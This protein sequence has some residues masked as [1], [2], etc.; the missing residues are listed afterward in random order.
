MLKGIIALVFAFAFALTAIPVFAATYTL[1]IKN[2]DELEIFKVWVRE[3][4]V[5]GR[6]CESRQLCTKTIVL[7]DNICRTGITVTISRGREPIRTY[8]DWCASGGLVEVVLTRG[9]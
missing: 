8:V 9:W 7:P 5:Q 6:P 2:E 3:G 1:E 4:E